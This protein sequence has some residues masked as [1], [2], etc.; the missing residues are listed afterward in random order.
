MDTDVE[1]VADS[2]PKRVTASPNTHG[3]EFDRDI[4]MVVLLSHPY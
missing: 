1:A 4:G 3:K 2:V